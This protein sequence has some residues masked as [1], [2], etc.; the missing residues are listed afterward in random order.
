MA[1]LVARVWVAML[2]RWMRT[3]GRVLASRTN[4]WV[5]GEWDGGV[6]VECFLPWRTN[7]QKLQDPGG[8]LNGIWG[9]QDAARPGA[10][11]RK[12]REQVCDGSAECQLSN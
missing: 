7:G 2:I 9:A 12:R 4:P 5:V 10:D 1:S 11:G 6:P 3:A 8:N